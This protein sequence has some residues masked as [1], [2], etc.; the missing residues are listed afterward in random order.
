MKSTVAKTIL[1]AGFAFAFA[2]AAPTA[3]L[4]ADSQ[5]A[6]V[7]SLGVDL[8]PYLE[9]VDP[10]TSEL[11]LPMGGNSEGDGLHTSRTSDWGSTYGNVVL[12]DKQNGLV[13]TNGAP[14]VHVDLRCMDGMGGIGGY[15]HGV[16]GNSAKCNSAAVYQ[17]HDGGI[18]G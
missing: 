1:A 15:A 4:A 5:P 14:L 10:V 3:A 8:A 17:S 18:L 11:G 13:N 6:E 9:T 12:H 16:L 2:L 7:S